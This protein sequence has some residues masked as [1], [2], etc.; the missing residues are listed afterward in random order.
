MGQ[1]KNEQY[2]VLLHPKNYLYLIYIALR[3]K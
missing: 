2:N 3:G 1:I